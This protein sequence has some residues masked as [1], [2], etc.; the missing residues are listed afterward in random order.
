MVGETF[1]VMNK[2]MLRNKLL[3]HAEAI[4]ILWFSRYFLSYLKVDFV[5]FNNFSQSSLFIVW[6]L[7]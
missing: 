2:G 7:S 5:V 3:L 1:S 6:V 4:T